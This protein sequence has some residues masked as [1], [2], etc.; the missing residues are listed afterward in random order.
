LEKPIHEK[1]QDVDSTILPAEKL[2]STAAGRVVRGFGSNALSQAISV[3]SSILLVP[4]Y[5]HA[6]GAPLY[7]RWLVLTSLA[8]YLILFDLGGQSFF[9]N[10]LASEY[11][12]GDSDEFRERFSEGVSLFSFI[13]VIALVVLG[14]LACTPD[15]NIFHQH[16]ALATEDRLVLLFVGITFLIGVPGG[17]LASAYRATGLF[18]RGAM[19]GNI[20]RAIALILYIVLLIAHVRPWLY[21]A[22]GLVSSILL[23]AFM[24]YDASR[25][26]PAIRGSRFGW[27][28][29]RK[30]FVHL[31]G[32][33]YFWLIAISNAL[34]QQG[35][36]LV[37][38]LTGSSTEV[39]L[40][41]THRTICGLIGY[42]G[43]FVWAP[44]MPEL[45]YLFTRR[46]QHLLAH[47]SHLA[48]KVV[49]LAASSSGV[50]LWL[51]LPT[52]Y[53]RWTGKSLSFDPILL[54]I[55][56]TQ[57]ALAA[58][59]MTSG[60]ALLASN[61]HR[62]LSCWALV[63]GVLTIALSALL[64]PRWGAPGVA[65][66]SLT[67]D[68][69]CGLAVY[70]FLASRV[71]GISSSSLYKTILLPMLALAPLWG[72]AILRKS[73]QPIGMR[74]TCILTAACIA[75]ITPAVVLAFHKK[76][77]TEW[78]FSKLRSVV[79]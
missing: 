7:G 20:A 27:A 65:F 16:I 13:A 43:S 47:A 18:V 30:G 76:D 2:P 70:P 48:L 66:A 73:S 69:L 6:W 49:T 21:A 74:D 34:N 53:P 4:L 32:S 19:I 71:L 38:A 28:S 50:G 1:V 56:L 44:L 22:A 17:I 12:R 24:V 5:L 14:A 26:I 64:A 75:L 23:A 57:A 67:G 29:A 61:Q 8:T 72:V 36:L 11:A 15:L 59:W 79:R 68:I 55:L 40:F 77:D 41:A 10:L 51:I 37:L 52:I 58:G 78:I 63:N 25:C 33:L 60:W 35:V 62:R 31:P 3:A 45:N 9:G 46:Q 42:I 39:A 54:A